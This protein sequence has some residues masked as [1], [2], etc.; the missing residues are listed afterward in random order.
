MIGLQG[1][2]IFLSLHGIHL[3]TDIRQGFIV[4]SPLYDIVSSKISNRIVF[5]PINNLNTLLYFNAYRIY[6]L[7]RSEKKLIKKG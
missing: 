2:T 3:F 1:Q 7:K 5:F 6:L 4:K